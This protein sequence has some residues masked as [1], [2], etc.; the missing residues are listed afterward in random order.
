MSV[1]FY[2]WGLNCQSLT[3]VYAISMET[4]VRSIRR[5]PDA[6][7]ISSFVGLSSRLL[8]C[9]QERT[10][11]R[12]GSQ[13]ARTRRR[14]GTDW[15]F[16][17]QAPTARHD[18]CSAVAVSRACCPKLRSATGPRSQRSRTRTSL[19]YLLYSHPRT[20][21]ERGPFAVRFPFS[22]LGNKPSRCAP[23][24]QCRSIAL[25]FFCGLFY[26]LR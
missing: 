22:R 25:E 1:C 16:V 15:T 8:P 26:T 14:H 2:H 19:E 11:S 7:K 23:A 24:I 12:P 20:R 6:A 3:G 9:P 21:C 18:S 10:A 4:P 13:R 5:R 17:L